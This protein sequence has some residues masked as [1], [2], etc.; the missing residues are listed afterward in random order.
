MTAA[1]IEPF[2]LLTVDS[3]R[4]GWWLSWR[5]F[6]RIVPVFVVA[7]VLGM[8]PLRGPVGGFLMAVLLCAG[9]IWSLTLVPKLTSRWAQERYGYLLENPLRMWWGITWRSFVV[10]LVAAV[11]LAVPNVV[12]LSFKTAYGGS[13]L[14][15]I[16]NLM[17]SLLS[18]VNVGVS[19]LATGWAMSRVASEQ[20]S[21]LEPRTPTGPA[22]APVVPAE[23][24]R[25]AAEPTAAA[26]PPATSAPAIESNPAL[27]DQ[28][29]AAVG[30]P[31]PFGTGPAAG[32]SP[33][34]SAA[35]GATPPVPAPITASTEGKKQ[36]PK[37]G[38]YETER[39]TVIGWY[40]KICGWR[41]ARR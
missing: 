15:T 28:A 30:A 37:C 2:G 8:G 34:L 13:L 16:A 3:F 35:P 17:L 33:T 31:R 10:S 6:V 36:C 14:G 20:L 27:T 24:P 1:L 5:L 19:I 29:E 12:A 41:E 4:A 22:A 9:A 32:G 23:T 26:A 40:C 21:G 39:G 18:V 11:I 38:L 25:T 7:A